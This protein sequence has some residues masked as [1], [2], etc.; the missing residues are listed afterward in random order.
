MKVGEHLYRINRKGQFRSGEAFFYFDSEIVIR[1]Y[2]E[3]IFE[4]VFVGR[5]LKNLPSATVVYFLISEK[6]K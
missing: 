1:R 4:N 3:P 2:F 6:K 5:E